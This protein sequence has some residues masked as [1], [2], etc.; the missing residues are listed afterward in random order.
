MISLYKIRYFKNKLLFFVAPILFYLFVLNSGLAEGWEEKRTRMIDVDL[1]PRGI[2]S[3]EILKA[4]MNVPRHE[5]VPE[6]IRGLAY[7]EDR[8]SVV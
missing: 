3:P 1:K 7:A 6:N 2:A 4:M 5:F 8:K